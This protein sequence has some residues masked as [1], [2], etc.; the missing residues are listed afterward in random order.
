MNPN[1]SWTEESWCLGVGCYTFKVYDSYGDGMYGA[2]PEYAC[3][4]NGDYTIEINDDQIASLIANNANFKSLERMSSVLKKLTSNH[5]TAS[6][7]I[8]C[9][10]RNGSGLYLAWR[11][12]KPST[13]IISVL[14]ITA[15]T[16]N[17]KK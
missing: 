16:R 6:M 4:Q 17:S 11:I 7:E 15:A 8:A 13:D 5:S 10:S 14:N 2:N 12:A 3:G 9:R 1:P